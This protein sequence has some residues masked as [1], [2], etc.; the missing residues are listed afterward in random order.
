MSL[1]EFEDLLL[2]VVVS[3]DNFDTV[4]AEFLHRYSLVQLSLRVISHLL[5]ESVVHDQGADGT[6]RPQA[7]IHKDPGALI[8]G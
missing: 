2:H 3:V 1:Y 7:A 6:S 5:I 4:R 8:L